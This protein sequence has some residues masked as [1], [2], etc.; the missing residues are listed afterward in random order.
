MPD[1][2][3]RRPDCRGRR[4]DCRGRR[5]DCRG[6]RPDCRGRRPDSGF[7]P[8]WNLESGIWNS[9]AMRLPRRTAAG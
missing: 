6:R 9:P 2:R 8:I 4:P 5:P 3:G 7:L 1:C